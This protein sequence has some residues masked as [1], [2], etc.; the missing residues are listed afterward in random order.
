[1]MAFVMA[2]IGIWP[3]RPGVVIVAGKL[4]EHYNAHVPFLL[5]T[6]TVLAGAALGNEA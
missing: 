3:D 5:G 1:M 2:A 6:A 4:V